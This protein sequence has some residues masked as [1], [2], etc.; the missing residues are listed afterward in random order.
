MFQHLNQHFFFGF[1]W[2]E[3]SRE[4]RDVVEVTLADGPAQ[5]QKFAGLV[6]EAQIYNPLEFEEE[7]IFAII[8]EDI[9]FHVRGSLEPGEWFFGEIF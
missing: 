1:V 8:I 2:S 7:D 4:V 3:F 5:A 6:F 9:W